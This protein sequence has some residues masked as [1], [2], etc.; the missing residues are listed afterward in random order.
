MFLVVPW[1]DATRD[2][3]YERSSRRTAADEARRRG[4][5]L[6]TSSSLTLVVSLVSHSLFS[7]ASLSLSRL[8]RSSLTLVSHALVSLISHARLSVKI[9][10]QSAV[11]RRE[12]VVVER[13][14][15]PQFLERGDP[16]L[17]EKQRPPP[18]EK[19]ILFAVRVQVHGRIQTR[20]SSPQE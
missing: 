18:F 7:H 14:L 12:A 2:V 3:R 8:S 6:G 9:A 20:A 15:H 11:L 13:R 1:R 19:L 17:A 5:P 16:L 4:I 10:S